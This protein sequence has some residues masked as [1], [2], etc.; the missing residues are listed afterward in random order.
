MKAASRGQTPISTR[1]A[2]LD[3]LGRRLTG[4]FPAGQIL[5]IL[6]DYAGRLEEARAR[7]R[8]EEAVL[9]TMDTPE[10]AAE[11]LLEEEPL[12]AAGRLRRFTL[13]GAAL[14]LC[15]GGLWICLES[16]APVLF[17]T[18]SCLFLPL[19]GSALFLLLQGPDRVE[20]EGKFPPER[21]ASPVPVYCVPFALTAAYEAIEQILAAAAGAGRLSSAIGTVP[22]GMLNTYFVL[23]LELTLL[24]LA[25]WL[26]WRSV[27]TSIRYFPGVLHAAGAGGTLFYSY[28]FFTSTNLE[29]P[30]SVSLALLLRLLPYCVGLA[31]AAVFQRWT[32][33]RTRLP[34]CFLDAALTR[35]GWLHRLGKSLL[36]WFPAAQV[37]EIL[38]DYR[39]QF[40]LGA[41]RG[42]SDSELIARM[43][44]PE[45]V[46]RDLIQETP[47]ARLYRRRTL[48]WALPLAL[49]TWLLLRIFCTYTWG[50]TG[51]LYHWY[52]P[53][54]AALA[55][56]LAAVPLFALVHG[57]G[58]SL[59]E[60]R[61]PAERRPTLWVFLA[62]L[63]VAALTAGGGAYL[64][65]RAASYY[66]TI[67][68]PPAGFSVAD[69]MAFSVLLPA[70]L[71]VWT[72]SRCIS[73]SIR[74]FPA[75][76]HAAGSMAY[77]LCAGIFL[78]GMDVEYAA[79]R[80]PAAI[81]GYLLNLLPYA[82][83]VLLALAFQWMI[84]RSGAERNEG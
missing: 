36:R 35:Q 77:V 70:V 5:D 82:A 16:A 37:R 55:L 21:A 28:L 83:G 58:Q 47:G 49:G 8:S 4:Y 9:S 42:K 15:C 34:R 29:L 53:Q 43:G 3:R 73:S 62:P 44:R 56:P 2:W 22:L 10:E 30:W 27:R 69:F 52:A 72:L 61:F 18:G 20:I 67:P 51:L 80:W 41:E 1:Q 40:E 39:E 23:A 76:V 13:W 7:T 19:A 63:A 79:V 59:L 65:R 50:N 46:V 32:D 84:R 14:L 75:A 81:R 26:L 12:A 78:R 38:E 31:S 60:A 57:R 71:L 64:I 74:Y 11:R 6:S 54:M 48:R 17:W 33:G 45:A 25:A 68:N 66:Q 24:L